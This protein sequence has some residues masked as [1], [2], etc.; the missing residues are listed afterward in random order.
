MQS[1]GVLCISHLGII[2]LK[3]NEINEIVLVVNLLE[4]SSKF[5]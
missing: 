5:T 2:N 3:P 4:I 1:E